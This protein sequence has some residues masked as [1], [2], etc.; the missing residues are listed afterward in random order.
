MSTCTLPVP[1]ATIPP[2]L[3][4]STATGL[5]L[6]LKSMKSGSPGDVSNPPS[7]K[8]YLNATLNLPNASR[9][10]DTL[11]SMG[12]S[13]PNTGVSSRRNSL[14]PVLPI[15]CCNVGCGWDSSFSYTRNSLVPLWL[16]LLFVCCLLVSTATNV[17][18]TPL[19]HSL[20]LGHQY[21][22]QSFLGC[23]NPF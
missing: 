12:T 22:W 13:L 19:H 17:I 8:P 21:F 7:S 2:T 9:S 10:V 11:T 4:V 1:G 15:A 20:P 14:T 3:Y 23:R 18:Q 5:W 16:S 6:M